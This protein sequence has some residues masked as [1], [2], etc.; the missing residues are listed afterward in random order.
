MFLDLAHNNITQL[1]ATVQV[2]CRHRCAAP[3]PAQVLSALPSLQA[4]VA[5]G[6]PIALVARYR[7]TFV[8]GIPTLTA[9]DD[10]PVST[11]QARE[12]RGSNIAAQ[13]P[14]VL[15]TCTIKHVAVCCRTVPAMPLTPHAE[16]A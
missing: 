15:F 11:A 1:D 10:V 5:L 13:P 6:N 8:A 3:M 16:P 4:V 9:L 7:Q 14:E 12:C 2:K